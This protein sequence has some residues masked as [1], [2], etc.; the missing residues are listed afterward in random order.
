MEIVILAFVVVNLGLSAAALVGV[1]A[2][3][4]KLE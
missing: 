2:V 1:L 3:F 4:S